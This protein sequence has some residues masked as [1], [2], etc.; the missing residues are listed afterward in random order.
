LLKLPLLAI[1]GAPNVGKSTLFNRLVGRRDAL[2]TDEVGVTRDRIYGFV[3]DLPIPF[4]LVDTGGLTPGSEAPLASGIA[5]QARAALKEASAILF[6]VDVRA[7][8]TGLDQDIAGLLRRIGKPVLVV[9]NKVDGPKQEILIHA[10]SELGMGPPYAVSAEHGRGIE[11]L[12]AAIQAILHPRAGSAGGLSEDGSEGAAASVRVALVGRP[13][14][15]KSSLLNQLVG[16]ERMLVSEIPGTTRDAVDTLL[17]R[18]DGRRYLLVDTAGIRRK[19]KVRRTAETLSVVVARRSIE[20]AD[21]VVLVLDAVEGFASQDAHI[22]GYALEA[23]KP[24]VVAV[25]KWDLVEDREEAAKAWVRLLE[26]RLKFVKDVPVLL[27][28]ALTG[29]RITRLLDSAERLHATAAQRVPTP[30]LNRWLH[31]VARAERDSPARGRSIRLY[32]ATQT[33]V[34]PPRFVLFCNEARRVHFSLRRYLDN[35]LRARFGFDGVPIVLQFR[36]RSGN[37]RR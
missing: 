19:G 11:E 21:V 26:D 12:L 3:A 9:A 8:I 36:S 34:R 14:V 30:E 5:R 18:P 13:N 17:V 4:R 16:E 20:Q 10:A 7:G 32:Y 31:Q 2:V 15:G 37:R 23:H 6:V 28:S 35:S 22:A 27:V 24:V 33:G 25:N 1:V 29:Q